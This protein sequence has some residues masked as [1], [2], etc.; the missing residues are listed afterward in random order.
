MRVL[1]LRVGGKVPCMDTARSWSIHLDGTLR[2]RVIS[3]DARTTIAVLVQGQGVP[4]AADLARVTGARHDAVAH[5]AGL[6]STVR[7]Y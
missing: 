7:S 4:A 3:V 6:R 5:D 2:H 1:T